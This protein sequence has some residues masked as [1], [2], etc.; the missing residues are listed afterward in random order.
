MTYTPIG[1][2]RLTAADFFRLYW[3]HWSW[4]DQFWRFR[5]PKGRGKH[6]LESFFSI[7]DWDG[8]PKHVYRHDLACLHAGSLGS[9]P[10]PAKN[11]GQGPLESIYIIYRALYIASWKHFVHLWVG[12][13]AIWAFSIDSCIYSLRQSAREQDE[14]V[15]G[16]SMNWPGEY[17]AMHQWRG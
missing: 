17:K 2:W 8:M 14:I 7:L 16:E 3:L 11:K 13:Q 6:S 15:E 4:T 5:R 12:L 1:G 10:A 9:Q